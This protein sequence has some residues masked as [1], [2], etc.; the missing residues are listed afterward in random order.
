M[1]LDLHSPQT[2]RNIEAGNTV[3]EINVV[4]PIRR[5]GYRF[6]GPATV[7]RDGPVYDDVVRFYEH[8]AGLD[9]GGINAVV[10][11][12]VEQAS[13]LVSRVSRRL[14]RRRDQPA[15]PDTCTGSRAPRAPTDSAVGIEAPASPGMQ[16]VS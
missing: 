2:V 14:D 10:M 1:F 15:L 13:A 12:E 5:K 3:V 4:D 11:V 7:H 8:A 6:K 16:P 9:H